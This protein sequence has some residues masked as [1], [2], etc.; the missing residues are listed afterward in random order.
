MSFWLDESICTT[1]GVV[2]PDQ[3]IHYFC[4]DSDRTLLVKNPLLL[5]AFIR[6]D[7]A[8]E[9]F[10]LVNHDYKDPAFVRNKSM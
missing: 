10:I 9:Y 1:Y 4:T 2:A 5:P 7:K 3:A 6:L 8:R